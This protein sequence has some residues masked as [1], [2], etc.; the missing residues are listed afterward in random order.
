M[1][2]QF[3]QKNPNIQ[4]GVPAFRGTRVP[5]KA[6]STMWSLSKTL[7]QYLIDF[8]AVDRAKATATL[9]L[10]QAMLDATA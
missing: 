9:E 5:V 8:L 4:G 10:A 2:E 6:P 1:V 3:V 7:E